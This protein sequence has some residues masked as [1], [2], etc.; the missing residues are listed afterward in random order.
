MAGDKKNNE[1]LVVLVGI[2]LIILVAIIT[3]FRPSLTREKADNSNPT[4]NSALS[5]DDI[6]KISAVDLEKK[7]KNNEKIT[8]VDINSSDVFQQEHIVDSINIPLAELPNGKAN[9]DQNSF[10]VIV[11]SGTADSDA[12]AAL[13]LFDS[14]NSA[15]LLGG[16]TAWNDNNGLTVSWGDPTSFVNTSKVTF[17]ALEDFKK[18]HDSN[19]LIYL[20][21]T[22]LPVDF[23]NGHIS[24]AVN[25]SFDEL[26]KRRNEIP[27]GKNIVVYGETELDGFRAGVRLYDLGILSG[28]V[29]RG[30]F[31]GWQ[32][33]GFATEK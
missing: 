2:I 13:K 11:G 14:K 31:S 9:L 8:F 26:E 33:K 32:D 17:I 5:T 29:M 23:S 12:A 3:F 28:Q 20:L 18:A 10:I 22:R 19:Q 7:I 4:Q 21:D 27:Q 30:G 1:K 24:G 15:V 16:V 6:P 25:I